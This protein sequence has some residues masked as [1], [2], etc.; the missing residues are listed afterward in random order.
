MLA[1]NGIGRITAHTYVESCGIDIQ[2]LLLPHAAA[3][4]IIAAI[5]RMN[6]RLYLLL[7]RLH[8]MTMCSPQTF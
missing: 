2:L 5:G 3:V 1:H 4:A 6:G 7:C 8:S